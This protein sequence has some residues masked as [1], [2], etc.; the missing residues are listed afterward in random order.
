MKLNRI[1]SQRSNNSNGKTLIVTVDIGKVMNTGYYRYPDGEDIKPFEFFNDSRGF[2]KFWDRICQGMEAGGDKVEEIVVGFESTGPYAEPLVHYLR[3]RKVRLVQVNPMHT[4]RLK[5]LQDNSP[6]KTDKK[7]PKVIAD[8]I[9]LGHALSLV[10]P[11][12]CAA[13]LRRLTQAREREIRNLTA[14]FNQ[15]QHLVFVIFPEFLQIFKNV[16]SKSAQYLLKYL[17]TPQSIVEHGLEALGSIVK[18]IS[19]GRLGN[20]QAQALYEEANRSVGIQEGQESIVTEIKHILA[21]IEV[22]EQFI[23]DVQEKMSEYLQQIPYSRAILSIK[24]IGEITAA[25]LIGEVGDFRQYK[26]IGEMLKLAGLDLYE[27]SSGKHKGNRHIS[28]RGRPLMRK[29]L[30]FAAINVV[31][32]GGIL[33]QTYQG[34]LNRGMVKMKALIAIARKLLGIIF[35]LVRDQKEYIK[36][37]NEAQTVAEQAA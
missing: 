16:K 34:Y 32:K 23:A 7:D 10:I 11:E 25:G 30:F 18:K 4:K 17:T 1:K 12:G 15:L 13:E 28:K 5:E 14:L 26:T 31:R 19:R 37:Y 27:I 24:G 3:K 8:I 2:G 22:S 21:L 9:E 36:G 35:A 33:H 29:L 6:N 20:S